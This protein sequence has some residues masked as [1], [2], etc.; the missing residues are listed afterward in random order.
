MA[1][2]AIDPSAIHLNQAPSLRFLARGFASEASID[3][4][5]R[6]PPSPDLGAF[7]DLEAGRLGASYGAVER[8]QSKDTAEGMGG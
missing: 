2:A 8:V 6:P 4:D 5:Y 7:G 1:T 3:P